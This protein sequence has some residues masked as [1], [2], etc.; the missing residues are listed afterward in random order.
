MVK[1]NIKNVRSCWWVKNILARSFQLKCLSACIPIL[2]IDVR[3]SEFVKPPWSLFAQLSHFNYACVGWYVRKQGGSFS[4]D[5]KHI[6]LLS[7]L[8]FIISFYN[9]YHGVLYCFCINDKT[10]IFWR[11]K[12]N[13]MPIHQGSF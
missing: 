8:V 10:C 9:I 2:R 7:Q 6:N 4:I 3:F 11:N 12:V 13:M 1:Q 5:L